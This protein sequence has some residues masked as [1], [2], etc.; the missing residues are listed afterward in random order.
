[1]ST[2]AEAKLKIV[3][4]SDKKIPV[5][6]NAS[7]NDY[8]ITQSIRP[9]IESARDECLRNVR[10]QI[11]NSVA[12]NVITSSSSLM[13]QKTENGVTE[14]MDSFKAQSEA[15]SAKLPFLKGISITKVQ[16]SYWEKRI[17]TDNNQ[18]SYLYT[19][20]YPFSKDELNGIIAQFEA[21]DR[22]MQ[23]TYDQLAKDFAAISSVVEVER[24]IAELDNLVEY[25]FDS[26]RRTSATTLRDSY[27]AV[28]RQITIREVSNELGEYRFEFLYNNRP[29]EV[30]S[31]PKAVSKTLSEMRVEPDGKC[32]C[33]YYNYDACDPDEMNQATITSYVGGN[34]L[35]QMLYADIKGG[36]IVMRPVDKINLRGV[37]TGDQSVENIEVRLF[38]DCDL[39]DVVRIYQITLNVASLNTP[40]FMDGLAIDISGKGRKSLV[41]THQE[42]IGI[43]QSQSGRLGLASGELNVID[44]KGKSTK[45]KLSLPCACNW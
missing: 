11:I 18:I 37:L 44:T 34:K 45:I 10:D 23:G 14:M 24:A 38:V 1:M 43:K 21:Q 33:V 8:I 2:L 5:W 13:A 41:I 35:T 36:T 16:E 12:Q 31:K 32:W 40:I 28:Y 26:V 20:K 30:S 22:K 15:Q 39:S 27:R 3:D 9:D 29:I 4:A 42:K 7:Q 6:V 17:E 25:F 19:I